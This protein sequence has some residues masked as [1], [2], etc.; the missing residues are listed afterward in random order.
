MSEA[1]FVKL[2][3]HNKFR[4]TQFVTPNNIISFIY[5]YE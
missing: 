5:K 2:Y 1:N 3:A 4:F